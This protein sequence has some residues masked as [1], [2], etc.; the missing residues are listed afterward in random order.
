M[1]KGILNKLFKPKAAQVESPFA[2]FDAY[3][4]NM[5]EDIDDDGNTYD[6][7]QQSSFVLSNEYGE[8]VKQYNMQRHFLIYL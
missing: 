2:L 1:F 4:H 6:A 7:L 8:Q 3:L 5:R